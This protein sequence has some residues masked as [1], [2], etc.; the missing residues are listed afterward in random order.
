MENLFTT[1]CTQIKMATDMASQNNNC[2]NEPGGIY[3]STSTEQPD[4]DPPGEHAEAAFSEFYDEVCIV[5]YKH[6]FENN[7]GTCKYST[8]YSKRHVNTVI[9]FKSV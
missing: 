5:C 3:A 4:S 9:S 8:S 7:K 2:Q 1:G 6:A